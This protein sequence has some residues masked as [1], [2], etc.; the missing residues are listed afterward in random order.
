[1][2]HVA[3]DKN[4]ARPTCGV[5][6][7]DA[8]TILQRHRSE[9]SAP[10]ILGDACHNVNRV[11]W[12]ETIRSPHNPALQRQSGSRSDHISVGNVAWDTSGIFYHEEDWKKCEAATP[13]LHATD[14]A[15]HETELLSG[16]ERPKA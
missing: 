12:S 3:Y 13:L 10:S 2:K 15:R 11:C 1:M 7:H 16:T 8:P 4:F 5:T 14:E 9:C 6:V